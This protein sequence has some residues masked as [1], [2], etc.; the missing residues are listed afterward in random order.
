MKSALFV[1]G[2]ISL[3]TACLYIYLCFV[4]ICFVC[5]ICLAIFA[6]V[7]VH[8]TVACVCCLL[9]FFHGSTL[10]LSASSHSPYLVALCSCS[11]LA[12]AGSKK[13]SHLS[14]V[15]IVSE[16]LHQIGTEYF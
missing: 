16:L 11:L 10:L 7:C 9:M 4:C 1:I 12:L 5:F 6:E 15:F 13:T 8:N 3:F 14:I 2:N